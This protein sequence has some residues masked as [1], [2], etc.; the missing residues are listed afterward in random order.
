MLSLQLECPQCH[1][2][3]LCGDADILARL[4]QLALFR[5]ATD[6]PDEL[7]R[8]MVHSHRNRLKCDNCGHAGLI[9]DF[10]PAQNDGDDWQQAVVCEVCRQPID[11]E[12]I[13]F[14]PNATRCAK[15]QTA[16]DRGQLIAEPDYCPK[17][18][19]LAELRV[20]CAGGLTRYKLFCTGNP[21]CRL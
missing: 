15:C 3:T 20:S 6:P 19:A 4:R 1:W 10:D 8:E 18:G 7:V 12:R 21:A 5:R 11:P 9:T 13:E 16:A 2:R 14:I 17:C